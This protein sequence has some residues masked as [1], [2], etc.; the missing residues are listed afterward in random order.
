MD[1]LRQIEELLQHVA[2]HLKS[3]TKAE[4]RAA[5]QKLERISAIAT[6]LAFTL[7]TMRS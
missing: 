7:Q 4:R 1:S 5:V 2:E 6:T 3:G